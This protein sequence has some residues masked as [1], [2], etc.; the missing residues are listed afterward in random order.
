MDKSVAR[1]WSEFIGSLEATAL[2]PEV[3]EAAKSSLIDTIAAAL[4]GA[5]DEETQ[6]GVAAVVRVEGAG[7]CPVWGFPYAAPATAAALLN[8]M[9]AHAVEL[10]D[11]HKRGKVHPGTV[12]VPASL[13]VATIKPCSGSRLIEAI[14]CGYEVTAR[15]GTGIGPAAHRLRG[16]HATGT[17]GTFGAAAAAA[18][19]LGLSVEETVSALGMAGTQAS[20]LW[21]FLADGAS[22]KKL[23]AGR[24][25]ENGVVAAI[26]ASAGVTG[27]EH[28]IEARDGGL[29]PAASDSYDF[30]LA[31]AE[32]G[33]RWEILRVDR[34]PYP[35]CRSM[36]PP[37]AG[38][39]RLRRER[40]LRPA[41]V[42]RIEVYTYEVAVRQCFT[43]NRPRN[44]HEARFCIPYG[45]AVALVDGHAL[46]KQ[47]T[48]DR[49]KD[50]QVMEL[51]EKVVVHS[52]PQFTAR[53]PETWG[54]RVVVQTHGGERLECV[55]EDA[56]GGEVAPLTRGDL[57]DKF[58]DAAEPTLGQER[59]ARL[60][61][62]LER[63]EDVEDVSREIGPL[64]RRA[65]E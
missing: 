42:A 65:E 44:V 16:W 21:A 46:T 40:G 43:T 10:D 7:A 45:L 17:C 31:T 8:G 25:A 9:L 59:A 64:L 30:G 38:I 12:V 41:A 35:C 39:L 63:V 61:E 55:V 11:V 36:H 49:L 27:P 33:T 14:V 28:I 5:R 37:I 1:T 15:C 18:K 26:L 34:K 4:A 48:G 56:P 58:M 2:P 24:A 20:G 32:L 47:F 19:I 60:L 6:G 3:V 23:H 51:A 13:S 57:V 29:Y 54:C 52:D 22:C 50:D 62:K 53:Y